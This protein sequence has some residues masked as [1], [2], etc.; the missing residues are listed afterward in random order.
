MELF[1]KKF[2]IPN[3]QSQGD[4][5]MIEES[6]QNSP[7][8]ESYEADHVT[9]TVLVTTANQD[10]MRDVLYLLDHVGFKPADREEQHQPNAR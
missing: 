10:G 1:T 2:Y 6:L 9:H 5:I 3:L 4:E 7:G 8:I